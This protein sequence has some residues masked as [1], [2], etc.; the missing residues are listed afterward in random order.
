MPLLGSAQETFDLKIEKPE[1]SGAPANI[2][3]NVGFRLYLPKVEQ[4][5][6]AVLIFFNDGGFDTNLRMQESYWATFMQEQR[7]AIIACSFTNKDDAPTISALESNWYGKLLWDS[8][9]KL[10]DQSK[11]SEINTLPLIPFGTTPQGSLMAY[12]LANWKTSRIAALFMTDLPKGQY[13]VSSS[14]GKIPALVVC[15]AKDAERIT[16]MLNTARSKGNPW[17]YI[18]NKHSYKDIEPVGLDFLVAVFANQDATDPAK[19]DKNTLGTDKAPTDPAWIGDLK[20]NSIAAKTDSNKSGK[21]TVWLP[22]EVFAKQWQWYMGGVSA[23]APAQTPAT[24]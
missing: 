7:V 18:C 23:P 4:P 11:H 17:A 8:I 21:N 9:R 15:P 6:R 24:E 3:S 12:N 22:N 13:E 10:A 16:D 19:A 2:Y 14:V 1:R 5:F 20:D